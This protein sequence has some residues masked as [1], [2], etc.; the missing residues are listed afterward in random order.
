MSNL[1]FERAYRVIPKNLLP[2]ISR[3]VEKSEKEF[4]GSGSISRERM[5]YMFKVYNRYL[6]GSVEED[7]DCKGCRTRVWGKMLMLGKDIRE[8][9]LSGED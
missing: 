8:K 6:S 3:V 2:G 5:E 1:F 4:K 9:G 7:I